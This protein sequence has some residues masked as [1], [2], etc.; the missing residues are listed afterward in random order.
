MRILAGLESSELW[1]PKLADP[2]RLGTITQ[3]VESFAELGVSVLLV[4]FCSRCASRG[5]SREPRVGPLRVRRR[6]AKTARARKR[7]ATQAIN[8]ERRGQEA[9]TR[10]AWHSL[11]QSASPRARPLGSKD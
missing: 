1:P 11:C 4:G 5:G 2:A 10:A 3:Q 9:G 7:P 8:R 6:T